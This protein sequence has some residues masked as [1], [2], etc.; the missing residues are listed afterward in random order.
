MAAPPPPPA[1]PEAGWGPRELTVTWGG[2]RPGS[3]RTPAAGHGQPLS[4][5]Q[6]EAGSREGEMPLGALPRGIQ[7]PPR[8]RGKE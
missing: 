7:G 8:D 2:R 1:H 6:P 4:L 5:Q 3:S